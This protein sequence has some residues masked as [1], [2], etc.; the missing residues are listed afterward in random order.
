ML[1]QFS[2]AL[3]SCPSPGSAPGP[4][5]CHLPA[6][7]P[8]CLHLCRP[9]NQAHLLV[10]LLI[11]A[12]STSSAEFVCSSAP[13]LLFPEEACA[14]RLALALGFLLAWRLTCGTRT[15]L[16]AGTLSSCSE[17]K[18]KRLIGCYAVFC[19]TTDELMSGD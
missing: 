19:G 9:C 7:L 8:C 11:N 13:L 16:R 2:V 1:L 10:I 5:P 12:L 14:S 15:E 17:V 18:V 4:A 3:C 6:F